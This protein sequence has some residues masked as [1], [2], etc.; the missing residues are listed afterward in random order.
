[1]LTFAWVAAYGTLEAMNRGGSQKGFTIVELLIVVVVIA[2]LAAITIVAYNGVNRRAQASALQSDLASA[3]RKVETVKTASGTDT[4][5]SDS[6]GLGLPANVTYYMVGTTN[7]YCVESTNNGI[8]GLVYSATNTNTT[9]NPVPC[10]QAGLI[11]WWK[12][13][14]NGDDSGPDALASTAT[15]TT[16]T[17]SHAGLSNMALSF[18]TAATSFVQTSSSSALNNDAKTFSF[19][20]RPTS[21]PA[22][23][24]ASVILAKRSTSSGGLFISYV[25]NLFR[26]TVDCGASGGG[27]RWVTNF[28]PPLSTWSHVVITCATED[29]LKLYVNGSLQD[30]RATVNR[31]SF[32]TSTAIRIGR[33]TTGTTE[34]HFNGD[35]DD[36][37]V[38]NRVLSQAEAANMFA[39]TAQ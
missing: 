25:N 7:S 14:G 18:S 2:I 32:P 9:P 17:T 6:T 10:S 8:N 34:Y 33:D 27:N 28:D 16:P 15:G 30:Q 19:W 1:V 23:S 21:W 20:M 3:I 24:T 26:L 4:Y 22:N 12:L 5:P 37:R 11:G 36:V 31:S 39:R 35:I 13:N 29:G 38:F